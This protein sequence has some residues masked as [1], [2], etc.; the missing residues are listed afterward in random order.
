MVDPQK[1]I[2]DMHE[3]CEELSAA[4]EKW[5]KWCHGEGSS[6]EADPQKHLRDMHKASERLGE[7]RR[8]RYGG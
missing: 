4:R 1:H 2:D 7:A 3:A 5:S 6:G 8:K